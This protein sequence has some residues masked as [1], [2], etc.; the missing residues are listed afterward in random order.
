MIEP[1]ARPRPD[2][3]L[4][5]DSSRLDASL[6]RYVLMFRSR[7]N[8]LK[9]DRELRRMLRGGDRLDLTPG[10]TRS[11]VR[12]RAEATMQLAVEISLARPD[13][14]RWT[15]GDALRQQ[16]A[17]DA[18]YFAA[19]CWAQD[20]AP[21]LATLA[22]EPDLGPDATPQA[23]ALAFFERVPFGRHLLRGTQLFEDRRDRGAEAAVIGRDD[24]ATHPLYEA[25]VL[26]RSVAARVIEMLGPDKK[27]AQWRDAAAACAE[28]R[29]FRPPPPEVFD[30][31]LVE[32]Q[33]LVC[34]APARWSVGIKGE[35]AADARQLPPP[36][37]ATG[38]SP[39]EA[40]D[41]SEAAM[42]RSLA[43][44]PQLPPFALLADRLGIL[45]TTPAWADVARALRNVAAASGER[46][47]TGEDERLIADFTAALLRSSGTLVRALCAGQFFGTLAE[48]QATAPEACRLG[49][50]ML[51]TGLHFPSSD[52]AGIN[53]RLAQ[54]QGEWR[55]LFGTQAEK[56]AQ[57]WPPQLPK[58]PVGGDAETLAAL[59]HAAAEAAKQAT[60][61]AA[62]FESAGWV[63]A[64]KRLSRFCLDGRLADASLAELL[65]ACRG[66]GPAAWVALDPRQMT[67]A[68]WSRALLAALT[69]RAVPTWLAVIALQ[70][71]GADA[72]TAAQQ[73][74]L[75]QQLG[76]LERSTGPAGESERTALRLGAWQAAGR[77]V[78]TAILVVRQNSALAEGWRAPPRRGLLLVLRGPELAA[79]LEQRPGFV[80]ALPR[81]V[82][83]LE[84][85]PADAGVDVVQLRRAVD[86]QVQRLR[87]AA[88][89]AR[90]AEDVLQRRLLGSSAP[91]GNPQVP[92]DVFL[93][94]PTPQAP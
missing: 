70:R 7:M 74:Q 19:E 5:A 73:A 18:A 75:L 17:V 88:R 93:L 42:R 20:L 78:G 12:F 89:L 23:R 76:D 55:Q 79:L 53:T 60:P 28:Q 9:L 8:M 39:A 29:G 46:V 47:D 52:W 2:D 72:L 38:L 35:R 51:S 10:V 87:W 24:A 67:L 1:L 34:D 14:A 32:R 56:P 81:P 26:L 30:A 54:L 84:E 21:D 85:A 33:S 77:A 91:A 66:V 44:G 63:N 80:A 90:R 94:R 13:V 48:P 36:Q 61:D 50:E 58:L 25:R 86:I 4:S 45:P 31:L 11:D 92:D 37:S 64:Q 16:V 82:S 3:D 65:C 6:L 43:I 68:Q 83:V 57:A 40:I 62:V 15:G 69:M 59:L 71:L 27:V 49:L 41:R 22:G